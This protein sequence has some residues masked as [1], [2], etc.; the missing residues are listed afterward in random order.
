MMPGFRSLRSKIIPNEQRGGVLVMIKTAL[1][2]NI[3]N[4]RIEKDQV[5]FS[6]T[7]VPNVVIGAVY[8]APR[9]SPYFNPAT[10]A[11]MQEQYEQPKS[12]HNRCGRVH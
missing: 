2:N 1:W 6:L 10:I 7:N 11:I 3:H 4:I 8:Q 12:Y 9:D 5:W